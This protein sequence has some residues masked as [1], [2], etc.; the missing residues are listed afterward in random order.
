MKTYAA[1]RRAW[2]APREGEPHAAIEVFVETKLVRHAT[3][4][5]FPGDGTSRLSP[6]SRA[7]TS[8]AAGAEAKR[9]YQAA[10]A[11]LSA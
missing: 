9:R 5:I 1:F 10:R 11:P 4:G 3:T 6:R 2:E 7:E 8:P